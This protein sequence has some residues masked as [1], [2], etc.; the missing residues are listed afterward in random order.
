[1]HVKLH[2]Y[3]VEVSK[4]VNGTTATHFFIIILVTTMK[5][6]NLPLN[7]SAVPVNDVPRQV[8]LYNLL[9]LFTWPDLPEAPSSLQHGAVLYHQVLKDFQWWCIL[10]L[11]EEII[12]YHT[13]K[14][15][16]KVIIRNGNARRIIWKNGVSGQNSLITLI[17]E[18]HTL[19]SSVLIPLV[20]LYLSP[21]L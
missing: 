21:H 9:F 5:Y 2:V 11:K 17:P 12:E 4:L 13:F 18:F 10:N 7:C 1:M 16:I 3:H 6:E 20:G 15:W 14:I 8:L 19:L